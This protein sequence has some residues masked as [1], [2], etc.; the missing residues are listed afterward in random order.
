MK[1]NE[2]VNDNVIAAAKKNLEASARLNTPFVPVCISDR[3]DIFVMNMD[4]D[5]QGAFSRMGVIAYM[6][7]FQYLVYVFDARFRKATDEEAAKVKA[8]EDVRVEKMSA[9]AQETLVFLVLPLTPEIKGATGQWQYIRACGAIVW[10]KDEPEF[11]PQVWKDGGMYNWT[12]RGYAIAE[13]LGLRPPNGKA[14]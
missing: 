14:L 12:M 8:G 9:D 2:F 4:T 1:N 5:K 13:K 3:G 7:N 6:H 11:V 10:Y